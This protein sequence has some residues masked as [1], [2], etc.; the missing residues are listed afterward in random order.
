MKKLQEKILLEE[1]VVK[2]DELPSVELKEPITIDVPEVSDEEKRNSFVNILSLEIGEVYNNI[3]GLNK[4][5]LIEN[6]A[7]ENTSEIKE[8]T[9]NIDEIYK[10]LGEP[11]INVSGELSYESWC[12]SG[13]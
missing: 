2:E 3:S 13:I 5:Y 1:P 6:G 4:A 12:F 8:V 10:M 9:E 11:F 7:E